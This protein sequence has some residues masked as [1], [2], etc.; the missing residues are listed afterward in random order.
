VGG[1]LLPGHADDALAVG[2]QE[3]LA[4]GVV[5]SGLRRVVPLGAVGLHDEVVVGP[6]EVGDDAAAVEM[7][8][9]VDVWW[10]EAGCGEQVVDAV[11][12]L[13]AGGGWLGAQDAR[14]ARAAR[15]PGGAVEL[16]GQEAQ[17][18]EVHGLRGVCPMKCVW[19][20]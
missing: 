12:Q 9:D 1:R 17:V 18:G 16:A 4:F 7:Q 6:A 3:G 14:E 2:L 5:G 20:W 10:C 13:G 15:A 19:S 11:L 8:G